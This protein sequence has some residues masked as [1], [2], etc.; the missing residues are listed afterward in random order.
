M[1][2]LYLF[3]LN[4]ELFFFEKNRLHFLHVPAFS[5]F[6]KTCSSWKPKGLNVAN[7]LTLSM[8]KGKMKTADY[9]SYF[10]KLDLLSSTDGISNSLSIEIFLIDNSFLRLT[11]SERT[12]VSIAVR[13][14][15]WTNEISC[16]GFEKCQHRSRSNFGTLWHKNWVAILE[17]TLH[18]SISPWHLFFST[19]SEGWHLKRLSF[20]NNQC[21]SCKKMKVRCICPINLNLQ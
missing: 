19:H 9:E 3:H 14:F 10:W 7:E 21:S 11:I 1:V 4:W 18:A 15:T 20:S 13:H 6:Q 8:H 16:F 5:W 12:L 2:L 17:T